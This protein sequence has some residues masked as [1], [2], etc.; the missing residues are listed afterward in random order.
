MSFTFVD[1][2]EKNLWLQTYQMVNTTTY[3]IIFNIPL[4]L[5]LGP[6]EIKTLKCSPK[7]SR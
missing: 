2:P 1:K 7:I 3:Q 5:T 6:K 4:N